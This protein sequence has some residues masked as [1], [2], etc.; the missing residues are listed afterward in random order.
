MYELDP[1]TDY[2]WK[3]LEVS[4]PNHYCYS[5]AKADI[6]LQLFWP[7]RLMETTRE[8]RTIAN[9]LLVLI[10]SPKIQEHLQK[11][12]PKVLQQCLDALHIR[13]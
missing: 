11:N 2:M 1:L 9:A 5:A 10:N 8:R 12:D 13:C 7:V 4:D 6:Q 3:E